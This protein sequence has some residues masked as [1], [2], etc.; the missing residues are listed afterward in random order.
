MRR[1]LLV[2]RHG[3]SAWDTSAPADFQRPLAERG[4]R[5][6]PRVGRWLREQGLLPSRVVSSPAER[7]AQTTTLVCESLGVEL[8][9]VH[10]DPRIYG[11]GLGELLKVLGD[12]P[13]EATTV[14]LIGHNPGLELLLGYLCS[15]AA[16]RSPDGKLLPTAAVAHL[17]MPEDWKALSARSAQLAG[18]VRPRSLTDD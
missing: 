7:A 14:L 11:G 16:G 17:R 18:I 10:W 8:A 12:V 15:P 9:S 3:K 1:R 2:L 4:K 13:R 6:V 5:D